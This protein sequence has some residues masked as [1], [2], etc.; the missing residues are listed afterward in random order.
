[1]FYAS[2]SLK[3]G[4]DFGYFPSGWEGVDGYAMVHATELDMV[5]ESYVR[6]DLDQYDLAT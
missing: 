3:N 2:S 5:H 6:L 1:V 4:G